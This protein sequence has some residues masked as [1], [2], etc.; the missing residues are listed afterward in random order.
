[1]EYVH[2]SKLV[3][4]VEQQFADCSGPPVLDLLEPLKL[5]F[6][7]PWWLTFGVA[8]VPTVVAPKYS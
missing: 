6:C 8:A 1:M 3:P 2:E 7:Q 5:L 4:V